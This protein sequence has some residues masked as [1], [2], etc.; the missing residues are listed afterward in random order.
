M[1]NLFYLIALVA[2][3]GLIILSCDKQTTPTSASLSETSEIEG[4]EKAGSVK[5]SGR[6]IVVD[7]TVLG[8]NTKLADS[9]PLPGSGGNR[10]ASLI[11]GSIPGVLNAEVLH[12]ATIGQGDRTRSEAAVANLN[13]TVGGNTIGAD[14]LMANAM[15]VCGPTLSGSS[16]ITNL[17]INGQSITVTGNPNQ[18][19]N[20]PVGKV[21]INEQKSAVTGN[22][23]SITVNALHV[24]VTGIADIIISSAQAGITCGAPICKGG[25]FVTGAGC[26]LGTPSGIKGYFCIDVGIKNGAFFFGHLHFVEG[27]PASGL[28]MEATS[29]TAYVTVNSTTRH[30]EG[31]AK[32]NGQ[33]GFTYKVDVTDNG[34][35]GSNDT[36]SIMLSNGYTASGNLCSGNIQ[37]HVAC[38]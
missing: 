3:L 6:A 33:S 37:L 14:F 30:I 36:F 21:V 13:V 28:T 9:G 7:A 15:A 8:I 1:K 17:V 12:A 19:I 11:S 29:I 2:A 5:F 23:G 27:H 18:T 38:K 32:V 10:R 4:L 25:D 16:D 20:L 31:A 35:L 26:I 24:I 22:T 34:A